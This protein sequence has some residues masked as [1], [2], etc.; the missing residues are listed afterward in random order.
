MEKR[1]IT[2]NPST[3]HHSQ[4]SYDL[5]RLVTIATADHMYPVQEVHFSGEM[6]LNI[7]GEGQSTVSPYCENIQY[8]MVW[9]YTLV[10]WV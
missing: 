7:K 3:A 10:R 5:N 4:A 8:T 9:R 6:Y 1:L 2:D